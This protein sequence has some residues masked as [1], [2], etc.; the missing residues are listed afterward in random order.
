MCVVKTLVALEKSWGAAAEVWIAAAESWVAIARTYIY[1]A[2][3]RAATS[4][5]IKK[6]A[7]FDVLNSGIL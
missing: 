1:G 2:C 4:M 5:V 3:A 7:A 6:I